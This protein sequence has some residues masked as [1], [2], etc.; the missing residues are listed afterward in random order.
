M[1]TK[2]IFSGFLLFALVTP[3]WAASQ[4]RILFG[5]EKFVRTTQNP[6]VYERT[7]IVPDY[8]SAPYLLSIIN[9]NPGID[10]RPPISDAV[11]SGEIFIDGKKVVSPNEFSKKVAR[12]EKRVDLS[13]GSHRLEVRLRSAPNSYIRLTISGV[14]YLGDLNKPR[15][16]HTATQLANGSILIAGGRDSANPLASTELFD[17]M[18]YTFS[19]LPARMETAR[20]EHT[21]SVL[22]DQTNLVA[23]G[24]NQGSVLAG[25]E[26]YHPTIGLFS[27]LSNTLRIA[28]AGHTATVLLDGRVLIT[29][30]QAID[31]LKSAEV[32]D[33]Q[34]VIFFQPSFNPENGIFRVLLRALSIPRWNHTATLL[35]DGKIL[36]V[37]GQNETG[38]LTSVEIFDPTTET[39]SRLI[40]TQLSTPRAGHTATLLPDGRVLV[41]GGQNSS[42]YLAS[43][44]V[45]APATQRFS[46][47]QLS[48]LN[49]QLMTPRAHHTATL[50]TG[51]KMLIT[52]GKGPAGIFSAGEIF[53]P[54]PKDTTAPSVVAVA[55]PDQTSGIDLTEIV[56]IRFSEPIAVTT[57][58]SSSLSLTG[59]GV[60]GVD[61]IIT[62]SE[63]GLLAFLV[64]KARLVAGVTY[65]LSLTKAITDTAGNPLMPF[66]STFTMVRAP[67]ITQVVPNHGPSG[68]SVT[69][70]GKYFD[71]SAPP[72]N[73][74]KFNGV[75]AIV[76]SVTATRIETIVPTNAPV[77]EGE[78]TVK[79]RGGEAHAMF[80]IETA[81]LLTVTGFS[82]TMGFVGTAVII[83][84]TNF[85]ASIPSNNKVSFNGTPAV[86]TDVTATT[87]KTTVPLG[88]TT[89]PVTVTTLNGSATGPTFSVIKNQDFTLLVTPS[90]VAL[91]QMAT[92]TYQI[93]VVNAGASLFTG[94]VTLSVSGLPAGIVAAFSPAQATV[95]TPSTLTLTATSVACCGN[96]SLDH[97]WIGNGRRNDDFPHGKRNV[98]DLIC[99]NDKTHRP[100]VGVER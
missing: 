30:G 29:G 57:L 12:I 21:A 62:P 15:S 59:G 27:T 45:Y 42:G 22:A 20:S 87:I 25:V 46:D 81:S 34:D 26:L 47:A 1:N 19:E 5:E 96:V 14:I 32:F 97:H 91:A 7:F 66:T 9:G 44:E 4:N 68:Q 18:T 64:P 54:L 67:E 6:T 16:G 70:I 10:K 36:L 90:A 56:G 85:D 71:P 98:D 31:T 48:N 89:G 8:V 3:L 40:N 13:P 23:G 73:I 83:T 53:G 52:G 24:R 100:R 79:T 49:T 84:G 41:L 80:T 35:P 55:P 60:V 65:T 93:R 11:S 82:P 72:L 88:A 50:L 17:P 38:Y 37:G 94:F 77:R 2:L 28:R 92:T 61:V 86:I 76:T 63:N 75:N 78:V 95:T 51:G 69:L 39:F 33:A 43:A 58:T 99:R 74:V